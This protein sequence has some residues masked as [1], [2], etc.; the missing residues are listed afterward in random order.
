TSP[1]ST[2][3]RWA[4]SDARSTTWRDRPPHARRTKPSPETPTMT[5]SPAQA[6][7]LTVTASDGVSL[8]VHAYTEIDPRRPTILAVHGYPANHHVG[9]GTAAELSRRHGGRY[10]FVAFDVRG[11]GD[12]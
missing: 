12:S 6:A 3:P 8:A 1:A 7:L 2:R 9:D 11:A 5:Q 4:G 10:N